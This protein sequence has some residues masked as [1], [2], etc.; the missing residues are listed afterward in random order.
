MEKL[1]LDNLVILVKNESLSWVLMNKSVFDGD[2]EFSISSLGP[3]NK[4]KLE[5]K[6]TDGKINF[7]KVVNKDLKID[8]LLFRTSLPDQLET[9]GN[10]LFIKFKGQFDELNKKLEM[11]EDEKW[12]KLSQTF[13]VK[14]I[15]DIKL[16]TIL[17]K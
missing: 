15:R 7:I 12:N 14:T 10:I 16:D 1:F 5:I 2:N 6:F 9:I 17:K 13:D 4:T 11:S 8:K 3:D